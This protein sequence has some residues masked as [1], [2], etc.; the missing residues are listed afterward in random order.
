[1]S[2]S[3]QRQKHILKLV[4]KRGYVTN[5]D[6]ATELNVTVQ[7]VRRDVNFMA[8]EN[9]INRHHGGAAALS[10]LENI[11]Y[12]ER[13][14]LNFKEKDLIGKKAAQLIPDGSSL[15]INIGTTT[16]A[17]A[18]ALR[19]H[20]SLKII[21]NNIHVASLLTPAP[22]CSLT[23]TG[24]VVRLRDGGIIGPAA[25]HMIEQYRA[26]FGVIGISGID[27]DGTLLDFDAEEIN[28]AQAIIRNARTVIL[29]ADHTKL[30]RRPMARVGHLADIDVLYTD[31]PLPDHLNTIATQANVSVHTTQDKASS[32]KKK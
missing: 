5:E 2:K 28:V 13:Q 29:L 8:T 10:P 24:G 11:D 18:R 1:M 27:E 26:D 6:L 25:T 4:Q 7:T 20:K 14:I 30:K 21:T 22:A 19:H 9:L 12:A 15:F 23:I 3:L 16:E 17:F 32:E 31:L